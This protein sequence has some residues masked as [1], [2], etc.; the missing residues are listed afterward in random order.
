[1]KKLIIPFLLFFVILSC[2]KDEVNLLVGTWT[3]DALSATGTIVDN[4]VTTNL[5]GTGIAFNN[6]NLVVTENPNVITSTG[7]VTTAV[8]ATLGGL[9]DLDTVDVDFGD[10]TMETWSQSGNTL[11]SYANSDTSTFTVV[12]NTSSSLVLSYQ[13]V[14]VDGSETITIDITATFSK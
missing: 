10:G 8:T 11:T 12:T 1:M 7:S 14:D 4:G 5:A 2:S 9:T 13:E 3:M 6:T